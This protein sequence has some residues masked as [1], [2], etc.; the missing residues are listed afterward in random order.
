MLNVCIG[1]SEEMLYYDKYWSRYILHR[2]NKMRTT[3]TPILNAGWSIWV[4]QCIYI[5]LATIHLTIFVSLSKQL[6]FTVLCLNNQYL[7]LWIPTVFCCNNFKNLNFGNK[8]LVW[9][10]CTCTLLCY[11]PSPAVISRSI[12]VLLLTNQYSPHWHKT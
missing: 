8:K 9:D 4:N 1:R 7:Y 10:G 5:I 6:K 11:Q 12:N 3:R 2:W